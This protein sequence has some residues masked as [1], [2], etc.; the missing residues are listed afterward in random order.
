MEKI[1]ILG[2]DGQYESVEEIDEAIKEQIQKDEHRKCN[3]IIQTDK[4]ETPQLA[5]D[6]L[7]RRGEDP[8]V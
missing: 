1:Y 2:K 8:V 6:E 4:G 3:G 5:A 7:H